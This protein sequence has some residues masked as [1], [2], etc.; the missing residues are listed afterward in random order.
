MKLNPAPC[1]A[2]A[3]PGSVVS[4]CSYISSVPCHP[5]RSITHS[6]QE[7]KTFLPVSCSFGAPSSAV[8]DN[9]V[10]W[11]KGLAY[12]AT[13]KIAC[14]CCFHL[15]LYLIKQDLGCLCF[16]LTCKGMGYS[17]FWKGMQW[18]CISS[19]FRVIQMLQASAHIYHQAFIISGRAALDHFYFL[20]RVQTPLI[21]AHTPGN[22][23]AAAARTQ[24]ALAAPAATPRNAPCSPNPAG[25]KAISQG[26][27]KEMSPPAAPRLLHPPLS[28]WLL[29]LLLL[30]CFWDRLSCQRMDIVT[31]QLVFFLRAEYQ[32]SIKNIN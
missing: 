26:Q 3:K 17:Q 24:P 1:T 5:T 8:I 15:P 11:S 31:I 27:E 18:S 12:I 30:Q 10:F 6:P 19:L 23:A 32:S 4:L 20:K 16:R 14:C 13:W 7:S 21:N 29:P 25:M 28:Q 22:P 2:A 9:G